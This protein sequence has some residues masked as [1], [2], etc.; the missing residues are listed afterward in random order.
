MGSRTV[1]KVRKK[2]RCHPRHNIKWQPGHLRT[3]TQ[4]TPLQTN[5]DD[6][7][8]EQYFPSVVFQRGQMI[9]ISGNVWRTVKP[10]LLKLIETTRV[11]WTR[12][13]KLS[14]MHA[15]GCHGICIPCGRT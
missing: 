7:E 10:V 13:Q 15:Q 4:F 5:E 9:I 2:D 14:D 11:G 1:E 12:S 8:K 6:P 3:F